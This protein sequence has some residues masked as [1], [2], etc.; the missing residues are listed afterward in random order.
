MKS[1]KELSFRVMYY[2]TVTL[3]VQIQTLCERS[4]VRGK[5]P[6]MGRFPNLG[7]CL[8]LYQEMP[9]YVLKIV[10]R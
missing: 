1:P 3:V 9:H 2:E 7:K 5:S 10:T 6:I 8:I 4:S